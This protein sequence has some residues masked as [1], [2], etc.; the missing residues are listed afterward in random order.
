MT[1]SLGSGYGSDLGGSKED[2]IT[3][4]KRQGILKSKTVEDAIRAVPRERFLWPGTAPF[5]SYEDEPQGLGDTQQTI[6]APHMV[7]IMLEELEL[8]P[9]LRILEIGTGSGYN[10]ALLGWIVSRGRSRDREALVVSI[11]R[12]EQ[13]AEFARGNIEKVDLTEVVEVLTGDGSLGFPQC[14]KE[15]NYDRII[16]TAGAP[17]IPVFLEYQ[18][19]RGGIMEVPVGENFSQTLIKLTKKEKMNKGTYFERKKITECSFVP[20][21]GEDA[22]R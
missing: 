3:S 9:G 2:L 10:A 19:R 16:V 12:D 4:L 17:R 11:E 6:S 21:V 15:E 8:K 14:S 18:L 5:L 1:I 22:F 7:V 13:L 20:F